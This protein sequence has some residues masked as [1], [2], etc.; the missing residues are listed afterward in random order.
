VDKLDLRMLEADVAHPG[1]RCAG[2]IAGKS[3]SGDAAEVIIDGITTHPMEARAKGMV[4][5]WPIWRASS[6]QR[7]RAALRAGDDPREG[8]LIHPTSI[9]GPD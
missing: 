9:E 6:W 4:N 1:W 3:L 5:A 8:R 2:E 7:C